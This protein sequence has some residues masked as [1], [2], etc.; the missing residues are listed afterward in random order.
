MSERKP[1]PMAIRL[2]DEARPALNVAIVEQPEP[3]AASA[4]LPIVAP[5]SRRGFRFGALF[6]SGLAGLVSLALGLWV[7]HLI[8]ALFQA[9]GG[10]G[11]VGLLLL[12]LTLFGLAGLAWRELRAIFRQREIG[13]LSEAIALAHATDDR[14]AARALVAEM[15]GLYRDRPETTR[16][17]AETAR[18]SH[19]IVDGRDLIAIAERELLAPLDERAKHIVATAAK[20]VS[21]V[22]AISPRA[23]LDFFFA[24]AQLVVMVR[25]ISGIYGGRP[26]FLGFL[27]VIKSVGAHLALTGGMAAGDSLLQ[28]VVGHGIASRI[29]ARLGEGV[30][31]GLMTTRVG[32]AAIAAC[33]PSPFLSRPAPNV[34]EVAPFLFRGPKEPDGK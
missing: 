6:A 11:D 30:L 29:S 32:L 21:M 1:R 9:A 14:V 10:L 7:T 28:Q 2:D 17:R 20:R 8:E 24:A 5:R 19:D 25:K 23:V 18:A 26:G 27:S 31:N 13:K 12:A 34:S 3:S 4:P 22:T 33:R 15:M 16:G